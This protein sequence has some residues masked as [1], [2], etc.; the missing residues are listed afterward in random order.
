MS[1]RESLSAYWR[2]FQGELFPFLEETVGVLTEPHKLF[3]AVVD[4][5]GI[6]A[7]VPHWHGLP[8]RPLAE[9]AALARAFVAKAALNLPTTRMLIERV[10]AD[11]TLRRL[12][13]WSRP[14]EVPSE[15]TFSRA[16]AE[17]AES[18][19]P[20]R[21]HEAL[22]RQTHAE[23]LV[24]HIARDTTAIE[25]H[26]RPRRA[27]EPEPAAP[28]PAP[29]KRGRPRKGEEPPQKPPTRLERQA[30]MTLSQMLAD[31]PRPCDIGVKRNA[32]G[33]QETWIGYKL[34]IDTADGDIPVS[35]VLTSASVHDSQVAI[36]LA[37]MTAGR[38]VNLYDLMDC[39]YDAPEIRAHSRALGHLP[40]ID[41]N[42]RRDVA[43]KE[44][45]AREERRRAL[46]A[47]RAAEDIR[48][49]QRSSAERVNANLKDNHG[50]RTVQVRGP[51][52]VMCHLMFGILV[53]TV[54]Q[55]IR[56]IA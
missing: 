54:N 37:T 34:H 16:F 25:G 49:N 41:V 45:L 7:F 29:R 18:E 43:L 38:L 27:E 48:Y 14:S 4:M 5:T 9:R 17:F 40:I 32:K 36:P 23:R 10:E 28:K 26:E 30:D 1:L 13:G 35:C 24:G 22:I 46:V 11:K 20:S 51:A 15:S 2:K 33:Y 12:C 53:V 42:P 47:H 56:L 52:K 6:E 55:I 3:V 50:G 8:G 21:V 44:E 19:L 39:A 31:L